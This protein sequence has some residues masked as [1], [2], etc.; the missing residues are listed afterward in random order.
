M[1]FSLNNRIVVEAYK[2]DKS[3]RA[4]VSNGFATIAQKNGVKGLKALMDATITTSGGNVYQVRRGDMVYIR[5]ELLHTQAW[6]L[7]AMECDTLN[8]PF[9]IVDSLHVDFV[10]PAGYPGA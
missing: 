3:L 1:N 4:N 8:E 2:T 10:V 5:E 9:L 7:K 6:A